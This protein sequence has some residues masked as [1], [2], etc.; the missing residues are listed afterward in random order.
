[1]AFYPMLCCIINYIY[2][3]KWLFPF[4]NN[5]WLQNKNIHKTLNEKK[6]F[7]MYKGFFFE[8]ILNNVFFFNLYKVIYIILEKNFF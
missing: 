2:K 8:L 5:V 3:K 4:I 7:F 6:V 1:M